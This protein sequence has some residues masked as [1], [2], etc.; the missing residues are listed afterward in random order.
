[1]SDIDDDIFSVVQ[2]NDVTGLIRLL[3]K[4]IVDV[5]VNN[6]FEDTPLHVACMKEGNSAIVE[7]LITRGANVESKNKFKETPLHVA[8]C[9]VGNSAIVD[10]LITRGA[11]IEKQGRRRIHS[12][13]RSL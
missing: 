13:S 6:N 3:D 4:G 10:L 1:M 8:C 12:S 2:S 5:N 7:L 9:K 11:N